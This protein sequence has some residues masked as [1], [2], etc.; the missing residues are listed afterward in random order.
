MDQITLPAR[1]ENLSHILEFIGQEL[2]P[3]PYNSKALLRLELA[4]EEAFVNIASYAY[5]ADNGEITV[6]LGIDEDPLQVTVQLTDSGIRFNPLENEDPDVTTEI[7]E[8]QPGG[9]GIFLIKKNVDQVQYQY[10]EGKNMLTLHQ[11]MD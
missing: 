4:V 5:P 6:R 8:K 7:E 11:R 10:H 3:F 9:L 1:K 2:E